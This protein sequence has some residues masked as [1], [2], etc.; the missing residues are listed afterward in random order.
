MVNQLI[1]LALRPLAMRPF[2][3]GAVR[4]AA[5]V[6]ERRTVCLDLSAARQAGHPDVML[7]PA[8]LF[9]V[10]RRLRG[11]ELSTALNV[12]PASIRHSE[13]ELVPVTT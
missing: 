2:R 9:G 7:L 3:N 1:G 4:F 10:E 8:Y 5:A 13:Q 11:N 12:P 6:G